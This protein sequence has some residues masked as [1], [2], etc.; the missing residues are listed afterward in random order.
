MR[1]DDG[2]RPFSMVDYLGLYPRHV[3]STKTGGSS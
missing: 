1:R 2:L 3:D